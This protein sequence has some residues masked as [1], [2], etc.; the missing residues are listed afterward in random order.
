M[1]FKG[2]QLKKLVYLL[3]LLNVVI[4]A[5]LRRYVLISRVYK[6]HSFCH[7]C[8]TLCVRLLL[9]YKHIKIHV[10][11]CASCEIRGLFYVE[12]IW[13]GGPS[14]VFIKHPQHAEHF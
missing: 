6:P 14:A 9:Y 2:L 8:Y 10:L 1:N 3:F 5:K 11:R 12:N 4:V 7:W 13:R